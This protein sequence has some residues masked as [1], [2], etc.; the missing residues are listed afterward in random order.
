[1]QGRF[2]AYKAPRG[3]AWGNKRAAPRPHDAIL[4]TGEATNTTA[5]L[6][7]LES[8]RYPEGEDA[9]MLAE[10]GW[11]PRGEAGRAVAVDALAGRLE[12]LL[13]A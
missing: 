13:R 1:M 11:P 9:M 10:K 5:A 7:C 12:E 2:T 4:T 8:G 3:N 6:D